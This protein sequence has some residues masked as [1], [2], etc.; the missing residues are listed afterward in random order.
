ML[1]SI[2]KRICKPKF[3]ATMAIAIFFMYFLMEFVGAT[4]FY[5]L[6]GICYIISTGR[7]SETPIPENIIAQILSIAAVMGLIIGGITVIVM[8][9]I[10]A[11][12]SIQVRGPRGI[13]WCRSTKAQI[14]YAIIWG[15]LISSL[16]LLFRHYST[17]R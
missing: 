4:A 1:F 10:F 9:R 13:G 11:A 17:L 15:A 7:F 16:I 8:T 5:Y 12:E 3:N 14:F 2:L 6:A